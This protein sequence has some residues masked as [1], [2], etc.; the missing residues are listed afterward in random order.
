[1]EGKHMRQVIKKF[2][3]QKRLFSNKG[4]DIHIDLP[5]PLNTINI[6]GRISQGDLRI[7]QYALYQEVS[8]LG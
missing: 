3:V 2:D 8:G 4:G 1:M 6:T 7:T 5:S